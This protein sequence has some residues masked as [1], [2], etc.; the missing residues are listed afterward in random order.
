MCWSG[1]ELFGMCWSNVKGIVVGDVKRVRVDGSCLEYAGVI[2]KVITVVAEVIKGH[3]FP[4]LP[5]R[6]R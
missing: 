3:C 6:V 1:W 5:L 2:S 4:S